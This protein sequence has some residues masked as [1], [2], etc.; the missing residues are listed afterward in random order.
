MTPPKH[1]QGLLYIVTVLALL[2]GAFAV[3]RI[4]TSACPGTLPRLWPVQ[5]G[6]GAMFVLQRPRIVL[7]GDSLTEKSFG[8]GGW[9]ATL[10]NYYVRK[11]R[12]G[13]FG[14]MSLVHA[15][16]T[17]PTSHHELISRRRAP[18]LSS[19]GYV[20]RCQPP[21]PG[22]IELISGALA[23]GEASGQSPA[24]PSEQKPTVRLPLCMH[25]PPTAHPHPPASPPFPPPP[26]GGRREPRHGRLQH[27]L[28]HPHAAARVRRLQR[29]GR[30]G[31]AGAGRA[32]RRGCAW[33]S[34]V[35]AAAEVP[36][37]TPRLGPRAL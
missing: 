5:N 18:W 32:G 6:A 13:G 4:H 17:G 30:I 23:V 29:G 22:I 35:G 7:F 12:R 16:S 8:V 27:A 21:A 1:D 9:G 28:G 14:G 2:F 33:V 24:K 31:R 20:A 11:V 3:H 26:P 34:A 36:L 19:H 15:C 25:V 37:L 10:A